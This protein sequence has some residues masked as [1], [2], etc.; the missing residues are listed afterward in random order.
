MCSRPVAS[1]HNI[2]VVLLNRALLRWWRLDV[3]S[4]LGWKYVFF[5]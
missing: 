2:A 3:Y 5:A 4:K 1:K